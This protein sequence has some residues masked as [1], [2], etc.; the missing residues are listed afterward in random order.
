MGGMACKI[1]CG[2]GASYPP[3]VACLANGYT[4]MIT[5][6]T[7]KEGC[8]LLFRKPG[9]I[10]FEDSETDDVLLN[11]MYVQ[12]S[13][14]QSVS[15]CFIRGSGDYVAVIVKPTEYTISGM[16][17]VIL[18][19]KGKF[20]YSRNDFYWPASYSPQA[21]LLQNWLY[22]DF[23]KYFLH[24]N[25]SDGVSMNNTQVWYEGELFINIPE[26]VEANGIAFEPKTLSP[27]LDSISVGNY[28]YRFAME[29][30]CDYY[31]QETALEYQLWFQDSNLL[32]V[33]KSNNN[34][35]AVATKQYL[36]FAG[37]VI[38]GYTASVY[39]GGFF[40][41]GNFIGAEVIGIGN[42]RLLRVM[43]PVDDCCFT[44]GHRELPTSLV[45]PSYSV[46]AVCHGSNIELFFA[47]TQSH[48]AQVQKIAI[49]KNGYA[50]WQGE[51]YDPDGGKL[52]PDPLQTRIFYNGQLIFFDSRSYPYV[53]ARYQVAGDYLLFVF[54]GVKIYY[55]G[56]LI[57]SEGS[58]NP[59]IFTSG[60]SLFTATPLLVIGD[61]CCLLYTESVLSP[62]VARLRHFSDG[63][64]TD[65]PQ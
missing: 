57:F 1:G 31:M 15:S 23:G 38:F 65:V 26:K 7:Q 53:I 54:E 3:F 21:A 2:C 8:K 47:Y 64:L 44:Q 41:N 5:N 12:E 4:L 49:L 40:Y 52:T 14:S 50:M 16:A 9:E 61:S 25:T 56:V 60:A 24:F 43:Q 59:D 35:T 34:F 46:N 6:Y 17:T 58:S 22:G 37:Q 27:S 42:S 29:L 13:R 32:S 10:E 45:N 48:Y 11:G 33:N 51:P 62:Y 19:H 18:T 28:P 39:E 20:I 55:K 63:V 36:V 30:G